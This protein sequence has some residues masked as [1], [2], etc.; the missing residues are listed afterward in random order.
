MY[1]MARLNTLLPYALCLLAFS[2]P[3]WFAFSSACLVLVTVLWF[4][5][6]NFRETLNNIKE[7][8]YLWPWFVFYLLFAISYFYSEN[9]DQSAFDLKT[10][11]A[12]VLLPL[13]VGGGIILTARQKTI[14]SILLSLIV[15]VVFAAVISLIDATIVWYPD[16][17][18]YAFFYHHLVRKLDPNAV[19]TAWYTIFSIS[20]VLFMPWQHY[21]QGKYKVL[22]IPLATFLLVFFF[23][24]SARMFILLFLLFIIPYFLKK[25]FSNIRRGL[26]VTVITIVCLY[27]L[28]RVVDSTNNPIRN[29][30]HAMIYGNQAYAWLDDYT[31]VEEARFDNVTLRIF[32]W[33]LG[34]ENIAERKA[35]LTGVGNGDVHLV[36][37]EKMREYKVQNI[38][39]P[40]ISKRP[41]FY[42]ANLHN[43]F[44][45]TL[46]MIG[47]PGLAVF[48]A[49]SI[50]PLFFI[51]KV[52]PYQ[53]FL[54]FHITSV[55]FMMQEAVLQTQA[56]IFFYIFISSIF[57]NL[58]YTQKSVTKKLI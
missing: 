12:Y 8:K 29:R 38:D 37:V 7:R 44:I 4:L 54:V 20:L 11:L 58:F 14:E 32:L 33:R 51:H 53:P 9:K 23:L 17:Y 40:D 49:I 34:I 39:N 6:G 52:R 13:I 19:Y 3:T 27:G 56:G 35:W 36:L 45:Q 18:Y 26:A 48:L 57:W 42:N 24:L 47:I 15:G 5:Q 46:V 41:G 1:K 22:K 30:Y 31:W 43:M 2:L 21:F 55:L 28:F 50:L 10:K 25:S 16:H